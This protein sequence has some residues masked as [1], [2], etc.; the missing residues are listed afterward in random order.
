M[1]DNEKTLNQMNETNEKTG[2]KRP[3]VRRSAVKKAAPAKTKSAAAQPAR[4]EKAAKPE[5]KAAAAKTPAP[6][7]PA[8]KTK[9]APKAKA[10]AKTASKANAPKQEPAVQK[11][12]QSMPG[13]GMQAKSV[14]RPSMGKRRVHAH[15]Q[16]AAPQADKPFISATLQL[17]GKKPPSMRSRASE[18]P[19]RATLRMIPLGGMC[20]IGKNM[21]AYEYGSD[22]I[23]VDCGQI[24]P[25]ET[26]PGVDAVIPDFTYVLQNRDR[27]RGIFITHGHEDHIGGLPYLMREFKAPIYGGKMAVELLKY[28]LDD[29]V[30]G[31]TKSCTLRAVEAGE[32]VRAGCFSVEFIHVNH[33]IADAFMFAIKTPIGTIVHSGDFKIDYTPINGAIMDLQR[34]AQIG[35]EGV[36][37]FVCES[38]NIEVP[39]FSK[40]ERHVGESTP[41]CSRMRRAASS[42]RRSLPTY[43]AC[44]RS[45]PL[46]S[47]MAARWRWLAAACSTCSTRPTIW[48]T[49]R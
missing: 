42:W 48:A 3:G 41:I 5:A 31:L 22:I 44:S 35:R 24:F 8:P 13:R 40:S 45:L 29:K 47:V 7:T 32:T 19:S 18:H 20:E 11:A 27:V 46:L 17:V 43:P 26:M 25:D 28:K 21:T 6:K 15:N 4:K 2:K 37:L 12:A 49:S 23:I 30:P 9:S 14:R 38:T 39:G 36:L 1:T 10:A 34:I 16:E 33:S